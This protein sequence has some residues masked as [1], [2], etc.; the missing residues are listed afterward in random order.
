MKRRKKL[1]FFKPLLK[2]PKAYGASDPQVYN[3]L[4]KAFFIGFE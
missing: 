3:K 1:S 2:F 4:E